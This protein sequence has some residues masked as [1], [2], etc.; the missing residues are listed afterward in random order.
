MTSL[1]AVAMQAGPVSWRLEKPTAHKK[2]P[3][4]RARACGAGDRFDT[5]PAKPLNVRNYC[6]VSLASIV[7]QIALPG[8]RF[9]VSFPMCGMVMSNV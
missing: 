4:G 2:S 9:S 6:S 8:F 3:A 1:A 7:T 5:E